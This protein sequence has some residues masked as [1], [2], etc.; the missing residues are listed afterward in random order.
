MMSGQR[1][2]MMQGLLPV[3]T[4]P[5]LTTITTTSTG[6]AVF[7]LDA[8]ISLVIASYIKVVRSP[9]CLGRADKPSAC[10]MDGQYHPVSAPHSSLNAL[11]NHQQK[12]EVVVCT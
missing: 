7:P 8:F 6:G 11:M 3:H 10:W 9:Y 2:R 12:I 4:P 5:S 1:A